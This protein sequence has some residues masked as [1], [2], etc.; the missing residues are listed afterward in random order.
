MTIHEEISSFINE[1]F[2]LFTPDL[3]GNEEDLERV[4]KYFNDPFVV[5]THTATLIQDRPVLRQALLDGMNEHLS[6]GWTNTV[7]ENMDI[8]ALNNRQVIATKDFIRMRGDGSIIERGGAT[9]TIVKFNQNW[10]LACVVM[11]GIDD[12]LKQVNSH[13]SS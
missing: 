7:S 11:H 5:I 10:R 6:D 12:R 1:Y 13:D 9:Y 8:F 2:T 4:L 3:P